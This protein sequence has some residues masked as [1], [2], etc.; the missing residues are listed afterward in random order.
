MKSFFFKLVAASVGLILLASC[1][2]TLQSNQYDFVK[3]LFQPAEPLPEKSWRVSWRSREYP[4]YAINHKSGT[5]FANEQGLIVSFDGW[6]IVELTLPG[7]P[8]GK[9]V[10]VSKVVSDDG[11]V[12]LKFRSANNHALV[13]H[14]CTPWRRSLEVINATKWLQQ[15][16]ADTESYQNTILVN[17]AGEL[18]ALRFIVDPKAPPM[19]VELV[20]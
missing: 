19:S 8:G 9:A 1:S 14:E 15:C 7:P 4:V 20:M 16:K 13:I 6:Q 5:F 11:G 18:T 3:G 17:Q 2:I 10:V 12:A